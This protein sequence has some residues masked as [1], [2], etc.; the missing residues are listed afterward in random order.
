M[1][2]LQVELLTGTK[3]VSL[4]RFASKFSHLIASH[5]DPGT[6]LFY[7]S[8]ITGLEK[9]DQNRNPNNNERDHLIAMSLARLK[10]SPDQSGLWF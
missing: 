1:L 9:D 7:I 10:K 8:L 6:M 3:R 2:L 4:A 5:N